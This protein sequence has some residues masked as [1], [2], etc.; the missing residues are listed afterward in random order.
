MPGPRGAQAGLEDLLGVA[1]DGEADQPVNGAVLGEAGEEI[2]DG[3]ALALREGRRFDRAAVGIVARDVEDVAGAAAAVPLPLRGLA[4]D[5]EGALRAAVDETLAAFP[6]AVA[7][8][9]GGKTAA[10]G[11]LIGETIR[12]TGGRAKP[13]QVRRLLEEALR[14]G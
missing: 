14:D 4:L 2:L 7:D 1:A 5:D 9:R 3:G 12:R 10:I 13:D 6:A 11:R 8:Y